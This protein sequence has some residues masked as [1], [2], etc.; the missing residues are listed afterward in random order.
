MHGDVDPAGEQRLF[1]LLD[2]DA[3]LADLAKRARAVAIAG[4]RDRHERDLVPR[5]AHNCAGELGLR[6][7]EP[8]AARPDANEHSSSS[9]EAPRDGNGDAAPA[10]ARMRS[11]PAWATDVPAWPAESLLVLVET[12]EMPHRV[13]VLAPVGSS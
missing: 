3:A 10:R 5:T 4:R 11:A 7:R 2:E 12:E 8:R 6:E 9:P 13:G 1:D